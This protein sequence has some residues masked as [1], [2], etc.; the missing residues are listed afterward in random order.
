M[1][2]VYFQEVFDVMVNPK[3]VDI[4][5]RVPGTP[6]WLDRLAPANHLIQ[7]MTK[8]QDLQKRAEELQVRFE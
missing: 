5:S 3:V 8:L 1:Y 2:F 7:E 6:A 4:S